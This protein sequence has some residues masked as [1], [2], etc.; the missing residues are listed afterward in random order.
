MVEFYLQGG[1]WMHPITL[2]VL[3]AAGL[4]IRQ[5]FRPE[6]SLALPIGGALVIAALMGAIGSAVGWIVMF[7]ALAGHSYSNPR[8]LLY[9]GMSIFLNPLTWALAWVTLLTLF[10]VPIFW[11]RSPKVR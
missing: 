9:E 6:P 3:I 2:F 4:L 10:A 7:S 5:A 11:W 1:I 8:Q